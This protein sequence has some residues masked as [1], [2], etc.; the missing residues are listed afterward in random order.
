MPR[1]PYLP[2]GTLREVLAYPLAIEAFAAAAYANALVRL[3]LDRL[4]PL[5]DVSR[6][7]DHELSDDEQQ[8][9]AFARVVLHAPPWVL[10]DEVLD[11]LDE[12][13]RRCILDLF[14]KDLPHTGVIHI[15]RADAHDHLFSRVLHLVKDPT[16]RILPDNKVADS[17]TA[18]PSTSIA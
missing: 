11:S 3:K 8:T 16:L 10:I 12:N 14:V 13:A 6:R 9:L 18:R 4:E 2:P 5:L 17:S 7:W 1:T 15:G